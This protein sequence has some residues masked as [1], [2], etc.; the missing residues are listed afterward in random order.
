VN[1]HALGIHKLIG[2]VV[3][4]ETINL[5]WRAVMLNTSSLVV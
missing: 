1:K 3:V 5:K 4:S 2:S